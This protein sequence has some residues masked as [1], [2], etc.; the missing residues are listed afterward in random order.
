MLKVQWVVNFVKRELPHKNFCKEGSNDIL[1][2]F[3]E[4]HIALHNVHAKS[5]I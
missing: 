1:F 5:R 2:A 3:A 4:T